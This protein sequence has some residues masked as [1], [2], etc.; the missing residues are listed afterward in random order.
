MESNTLQVG[1]YQDVTYK[2][3]L[4]MNCYLFTNLS[5]EMYRNY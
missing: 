2:W 3:I 4:Y 5:Q 1:N